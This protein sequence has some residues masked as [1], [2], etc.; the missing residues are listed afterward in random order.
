VLGEN[1]FKQ[2]IE[3]QAGRRSSPLP[4]GSDRKSKAY[5]NKPL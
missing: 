4:K 1:R 2:Q 5:K 3:E